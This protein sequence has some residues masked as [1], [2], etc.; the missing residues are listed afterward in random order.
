MIDPGLFVGR[1]SELTLMKQTLKPDD[2]SEGEQRLVLGGMGGIGKTQLAVAYLQQHCRLYDSIIWLNATSEL[3]LKSSVRSVAERLFPIQEVHTYEDKR[4][5]RFV[6]RWL[7][8]THNTKW[9]MIFDNYDEPELFDIQKYYPYTAQGNIIVTTRRPDQVGGVKVLVRPLEHVDDSL[10][11]LEA[12]SGRM[13][14]TMG[15]VTKQ[16]Y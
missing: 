8:D 14:I 3:T 15:K 2:P 7:S 13:K 4:N 10:R 16:R 5:L 12:R 6:R 1:I 11:V 9:L